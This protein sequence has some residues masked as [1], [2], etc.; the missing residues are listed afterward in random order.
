[1][2]FKRIWIRLFKKP[3]KM[4]KENLVYRRYL[5]NGGTFSEPFLDLPREYCR[6]CIPKCLKRGLYTVEDL[7]NYGYKIVYVKS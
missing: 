5:N 4:C 3:C 7:I 6:R 1:M 2:K